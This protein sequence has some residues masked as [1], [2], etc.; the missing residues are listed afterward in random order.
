MTRDLKSQID[1]RYRVLRDR[2]EDFLQ[3]DSRFPHFPAYYAISLEK[4]WQEVH[5]MVS[6]VSAFE[7]ILSSFIHMAVNRVISSGQRLH[8]LLLYDFLHRYYCT[9]EARDKKVRTS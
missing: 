4:L 5:D 7:Q 6:D 1:H 3:D 9:Q 8:E 2:I